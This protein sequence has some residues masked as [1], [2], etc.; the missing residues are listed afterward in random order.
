MLPK[1]LRASGRLSSTPN[2]TGALQ[3][4]ELIPFLACQGN[5]AAREAI[6]IKAV[7]VGAVYLMLSTLSLRLVQIG[8]RGSMMPKKQTCRSAADRG[9]VAVPRSEIYRLITSAGAH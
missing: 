6:V 9:D 5:Q 4:D 8:Q 1:P 3:G 2:L 7:Q